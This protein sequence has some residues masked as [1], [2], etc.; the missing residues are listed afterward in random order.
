MNLSTKRELLK[1]KI[2][3]N[4]H[5]YDTL[6]YSIIKNDVFDEFI[7]KI[8]EETFYIDAPLEYDEIDV[9][10][11][12]SLIDFFIRVL[13]NI[14]YGKN[15][16]TN[17]IEAIMTSNKK[18]MAQYCHSRT[19][20]RQYDTNNNDLDMIIYK[21][22]ITNFI[23]NAKYID[24]IEE[25]L[26]ERRIKLKDINDYSDKE[27]CKIVDLLSDIVFCE[28]PHGKSSY[29]YLFSNIDGG[30]KDKLNHLKQINSK[31]YNDAKYRV[32]YE[33]EYLDLYLKRYKALFDYYYNKKEYIKYFK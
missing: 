20:I 16:S 23:K 6:T 21:L 18:L 17:T 3:H 31:K 12:I 4:A 15:L 26:E 10:Q 22:I 13:R 14:F 32:K 8:K 33:N 5:N 19:E 25:V 2:F 1:Y 9:K 11:F 30:V 27:V 7:E 24:S 29:S 28:R